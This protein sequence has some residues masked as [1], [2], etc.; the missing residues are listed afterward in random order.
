MDAAGRSVENQERQK[1]D[2]G[3]GF[4]FD[5]AASADGLCA[6]DASPEP[7]GS[8]LPFVI[9]GV[10]ASAG[11]LESLE[12][13]FRSMPVNMGAAFV[14][15]QHL[16]PDF[17][18]LMD[19]LLSRYT[20]LPIHRAEHGM[21]VEPN[22]IYLIPPR[23]EMIVSNRRLLLTDKE[24]GQTLSMPIDRF[25][26]S[27]AQ[28][29]GKF[30]IGVILSGSGSDGSRG[31]RD[32]HAAGGLVICESEETAKFDG[33]PLATL[34]TGDVDVV[35]APEQIPAVIE[36]H[37]RQLPLAVPA[38]LNEPPAELE[39]IQ[40][41]F[42]LLNDHHGIDF[43]H[44][45]PNT[46][47]RR[48]QRRLSLHQLNS[49]P[50][51]AER[52]SSDPAELNALYRD[53]LIGVTRFFRDPEAFDKLEREVI[54]ELLAR[55]EDEVRVWAA[56]CATGEEAYSLA[57]LLRERLDA[58]GRKISVK[59]FATDVHRASLATAS[60]GIYPA[61]AVAEVSPERLQRFFVRRP[62]GF[63]VAPEL[64]QMLVFA[65]HNVIKDAPFT[66]MDLIVCRNLL[67]YFRPLAQ[68]KAVSLFHFGLRTGGV[69][70]LGPSE[71]PGE[72]QDEFE[73][74]DGHWKMYRKSRDVRLPVD[75]RSPSSSSPLVPRTATLPPP[76]HRSFPDPGLV[77]AYDA[78]LAHFM[79][80]AILINERRELLHVFGGAEKFLSV[81]PGRPS[82]D[83]LDSLV[84]DLRTA[85][86]GAVQRVLKERTPVQY[87]GIHCRT[88]NGEAVFN[89]TVRP[90]ENPRSR[91]AQILI[92]IEPVGA[93]T[94]TPDDAG[95][96]DTQQVNRDRIDSLEA[97]LRF[98]KEN[99]QATIEELET[100]NEEMQA[101][102]EELVASNEEL[103]STNEE[104]QSVNEELFTVNAE[105]QRKI[106]ELSEL[107]AD[108]DNL[109]ESTEIG[110]IFLDKDLNIRKFTP[111]VGQT[112]HLL[113]QDI[114]RPIASFS[115]SFIYEQRLDD[116]FRRVRDTHEACFREVRSQ[117]GQWWYLRILPYRKKGSFEGVVVTLI[118]ITSLKRAEERLADAV[119]L[120]DE[121]LAMLSHELRNPLAAIQ[122]A[123]QLLNV[124]CPED[125]QTRDAVDVV[126][127]QSSHLGRLLDDL[128]DVS[129][130]TQRK[131]ELR[132]QPC[133]IAEVVRNALQATRPQLEARRI[134]FSQSFDEAEP[135]RVEGDPAR[136]QQVVSNVLINA[137]KYTPVGGRVSLQV[138]A[139]DE[140]VTLQVRD[141]GVGIPGDKLDSI[142]ELF[143]QGEGTLHRSGTGMG[144][145]LTLARSII[146]LHGGTI[147]ARSDGLNQGSEFEIRLPRLHGRQPVPRPAPTRR[148]AA[149]KFDC[150]V[151]LVEDSA[152]NRRMLKQLLELQGC[153]VVTAENGP[154]GLAA[155]E[156][157]QPDLALI[158]IGLPGLDGYELAH[159]V[160]TN[161]GN[162]KTY[163]AALTGY[164]QPSDVRKALDAGFDVHLVKP[165]NLET[166][167]Q[168]LHAQRRTRS[169]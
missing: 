143:V 16:S 139:D 150:R 33:M 133:D 167:R 2:D 46:V 155:I 34:G 37:I 103:Q 152:D 39:G 102:N 56:G 118:D 48:I 115:H 14:V 60:E 17:K 140:W 146:E 123:A 24:P 36:Q 7:P 11:G 23:K 90:V 128:L 149:E 156:Q 31:V 42:R 88:E 64:R 160:R 111:Q 12:R 3:D 85:V 45:K 65:T 80:P 71:T 147:R 104:L 21:L 107:T 141:S 62:D 4:E 44:Y 127:R 122:N 54:P 131:I 99:L 154:R 78:I 6:L 119:R 169:E 163:L 157:H 86:V 112:F 10:G 106:T 22:S 89:L 15:I 101:T 63:Q 95:E 124:T 110:T 19:E 142:F 165:V 61:D 55:G 130:V 66:K 121:F 70:W 73:T 51:Y 26:R 38:S 40:T 58:A 132:P 74:I 53:L 136:L 138:R 94:A 120:R 96:F 28:D 125:E 32:I 27:L 43:S 93:E 162:S 50:E 5:G 79:P 9:V 82:Q 47:I 129:R 68:K 72:F 97:E 67:I 92:V 98:S 69:L 135:L 91:L 109:L 164:G 100:S 166:L 8:D 116:E 75:L 13:M 113:P 25:F 145:G 84:S 1:L 81:K 105:Y 117:S 35:V 144:I 77:G 76:P 114:G 158:D 87:A 151:V 126:H 52:L 148:P 168:I 41:V 30:S 83:A 159:Q 49:L 137:A 161:L 20:E 29:A 57:I 18:S 153:T 134:E 108:M 59:I